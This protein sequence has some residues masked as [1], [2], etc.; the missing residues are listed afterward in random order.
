METINL[1]SNT[2]SSQISNRMKGENVSGDEYRIGIKSLYDLYP[3]KTKER[4]L[5]DMKLNEWDEPHKKA[6]AEVARNIE[7]FNASNS[8]NSSNI[9]KKCRV[10]QILSC[11]H[12]DNRFDGNEKFIPICRQHFIACR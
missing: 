7:E 2:I 8:S 4:V 5:N 6:I 12:M 9:D 11:C 1:T 10:Y 3:S